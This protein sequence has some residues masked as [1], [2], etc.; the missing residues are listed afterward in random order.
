MSNRG[1]SMPVP[2]FQSKAA[3]LKHTFWPIDG[4]IIQ[5]MMVNI[6]MPLTQSR[7]LLDDPG[8]KNIFDL[9]RVLFYIYF[10]R[11]FVMFF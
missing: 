4:A 10:F 1:F 9:H 2:I 8:K 3:K 7:L 6:S 5:V 11:K